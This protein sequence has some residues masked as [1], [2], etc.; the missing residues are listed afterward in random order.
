M[1]Y[2]SSATRLLS[3]RDLT[4]ILRASNSNNKRLNIT[5]MLLFANGSF[6]QVLEG[7]EQAVR[8]LYEKIAKDPRHS[9]I[10]LIDDSEIDHPVFSSW[11]MGYKNLD[12][13][14]PNAL[15][16]YTDFLDRRVPPEE[17]LHHKDAVAE[18][19]Y[20]FAENNQR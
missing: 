18:L 5:G 12:M 20:Q 3:S 17:F 6:I 2:V 8:L 4:Q 1:I 10:T 19:L 14:R 9:H 16:G 13:E 15:H 7:E 11:S